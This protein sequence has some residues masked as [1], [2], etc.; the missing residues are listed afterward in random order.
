MRLVLHGGALSALVRTIPHLL[1][2]VHR[3]GGLPT[4]NGQGYLA[5]PWTPTTTA[6]RAKCPFDVRLADRC[7]M[8][9]SRITPLPNVLVTGPIR[10]LPVPGEAVPGAEHIRQSFGERVL[11]FE[12]G[13]SRTVHPCRVGSVITSAKFGGSAPTGVIQNL[14]GSVRARPKDASN[15]GTDD[16]GE[17]RF[18][19]NF[20]LYR[21]MV[22]LSRL[23][24]STR[25]G[26]LAL[27]GFSA[28][29]DQQQPSLRVVHDGT[30]A[31]DQR[32]IGYDHQHG[33]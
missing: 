26:P 18:F 21:R 30:Y 1:K 33:G 20:A 9:E 24:S 23:D 16:D 3:R 19:P 6:T 11:A 12:C 25:E 10:T 31:A 28:A 15:Q 13:E 17:S 4:A 27:S 22:G 8:A 5:T 2:V 7:R 14:V 29:Q 32:P